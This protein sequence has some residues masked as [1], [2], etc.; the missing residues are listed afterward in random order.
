MLVLW[1]KRVVQINCD[2]DVERFD[3][4]VMVDAL[5]R[6]VFLVEYTKQTRLI[7][8]FKSGENLPNHDVE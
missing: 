7:H 5:H 2:V 1:R 8:G 3:Q 4:V 6:V